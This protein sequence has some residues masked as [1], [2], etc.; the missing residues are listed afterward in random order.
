VVIL[1]KFNVE[2][3]EKIEIPQMRDFGT[4]ERSKL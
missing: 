1:E 2:I 4:P 3:Q